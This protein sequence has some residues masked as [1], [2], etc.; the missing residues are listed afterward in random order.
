MNCKFRGGT[1]GGLR[2]EGILPGG[3]KHSA[4]DLHLLFDARMNFR[5]EAQNRAAAKMVPLTAGQL[6]ASFPGCFGNA[7]R[8][9]F[10]TRSDMAVDRFPTGSAGQ[11]PR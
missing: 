7:D 3:T 11:I 4:S 5:R 8:E 10:K 2:E 6:P 9:A 1:G